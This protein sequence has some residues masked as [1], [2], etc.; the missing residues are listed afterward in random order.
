MLR[1]TLSGS[2]GTG[3]EADTHPG[4]GVLREP[5]LRELF[6]AAT[7]ENQPSVLFER[8]P[9]DGAPAQMA[10]DRTAPPA[11]GAE[12]DRDGVGIRCPIHPSLAADGM[13]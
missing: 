13:I 9:R 12:A 10:R 11:V 4:G 2:L 8:V 6:P 5:A 7:W 3:T 1:Q